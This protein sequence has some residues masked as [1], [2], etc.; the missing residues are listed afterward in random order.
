MLA[1]FGIVVKNSILI[2]DKIQA[3]EKTEM[4]FREGVAEGSASRL[5]PIA[6]T[7][8]TAILGLIPI[9]FLILYGE[10]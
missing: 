9:T 7:S 8:L 2:V 1:L 5:E 10:D 4:D 6:L 3:N